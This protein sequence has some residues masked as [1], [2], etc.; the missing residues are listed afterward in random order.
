[1]GK[2]SNITHECI[3]ALK[4]QEHYGES[5]FEDKKE[6]AKKA[7]EEGRAFKNVQGSY[8]FNTM[9]TYEKNC[10]HFILRQIVC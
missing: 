6:A 7:K 1:M 3:K 2:K 9:K 10:K 5:K 8:S 4:K